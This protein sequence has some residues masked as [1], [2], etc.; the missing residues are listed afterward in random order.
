MAAVVRVPYGVYQECGH[1][2]ENQQRPD[3]DEKYRQRI[4]VDVEVI[5][6]VERLT[7]N[8]DTAAYLGA[9]VDPVVDTAIEVP[10]TSTS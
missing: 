7:V 3:V 9:Q 6:V 2:D 1:D 10:A 4:H 8:H 5:G